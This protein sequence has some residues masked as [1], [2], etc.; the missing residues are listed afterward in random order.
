MPFQPDKGGSVHAWV[1][2]GK[3]QGGKK[4]NLSVKQRKPNSK[5]PCHTISHISTI[6]SI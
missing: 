3:P 4:K 6:K 2:V 5:G 1:N